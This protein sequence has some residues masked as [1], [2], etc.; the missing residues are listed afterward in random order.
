MRW[1]VAILVAAGALRLIW[2][3]VASHVPNGLSDPTFYFYS[4]IDIAHGAG[5][6]RN[7]VPTAYFPPAWS[8]A[9][10][11][12]FWLVRHTPLPDDPFPAGLALNW[13]LAVA[14]MGLAYR[15]GSRLFD[16]TTGLVTAGLVALCPSLIFF[17]GTYFSETQ[18]VFLELAALA[19]V[20]ASDRGRW[21]ARRLVLFG[22]LVGL[23]SLTR[24]SGTTRAPPGRSSS[25]TTATA[26]C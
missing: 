24:A 16:S 15:L 23:A 1:L 4:G 10:G 6:Q 20:A 12:V 26:P 25:T 14:S 7:G 3:L 17:S 21:P 9:L 8:L 11:G 18:F 2:M 13:V 22:L 5:Y 19:A